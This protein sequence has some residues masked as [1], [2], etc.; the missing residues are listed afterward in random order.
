[1]KYLSDGDAS[2]W[3]VETDGRYAS[4]IKEYLSKD[5]IPEEGV[6]NIIFNAARALGYCPNPRDD[7]ENRETGLIIGKVQSG[8]TS[9]FISLTAL[10]F[11]NNYDIVIV[12]GGTKNAL[13]SQN[14]ERIREYFQ[15]M[16]N[17]INVLDTNENIELLNEQRISQFIRM[18]RKIVIVSLKT[19]AKINLLINN[20]FDSTSLSEKPILIIDDEGDEASLNTLVKKGKKSA[21]Y[22]AIEKLKGSLRRHCFISVTA[23]PQANMLIE[24][25]DV[26][27]PDFGLLVDPGEGYCGLDVFHG[28]GSQNIIPI[29]DKETSLL[30]D[31]IPNSFFTALSIFFVGCG[32]MKY[33]G[34]RPNE[35]FSMLIHPSQLKA[36]HSKAFDKTETLLKKWEYFARN[37]KD[38][39]YKELRD[40]LFEAYNHYQKTIALPPFEILEPEILNAI[41]CCGRHVVNGNNVPKN[42]DKYYPYNIYVGGNLLGRGLTLKG[43]AITYIIRTAKGVSTVDTVQQRARWFGYKMKYIDLCRVFA[44]K[45]IIKEFSEIRDHEEDL[46]STVRNANLQ[47]ARFKEI[48]RIFVLSDSMRMTR[49]S[50]ANTRNY[51]FSFWNYQRIFQAVPEYR[52]NNARVIEAFR[53]KYSHSLQTLT[54]GAARPHKVLY[55]CKYDEVK[56]EIIDKFIFPEGSKLNKAMLDKLSILMKE[57]GI[58]PYIDVIWMRDGEPAKHPVIDGHISN[59]MVG[60]RP[61][62]TTKPVVY[63]GDNN[64][65]V[66]DDM[67]QLQ[68]HLIQKKDSDECSHTLALYIPKD[69]VAQITNLVIRD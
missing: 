19:S 3:T 30:D 49:A 55:N 16:D 13:V 29:P 66:K 26:L 17:E 33:R 45:K 44:S 50:V 56:Q 58:L 57:K 31:G 62:D 37:D 67:M 18:G 2:N 7:T 65:L 24:A 47:G 21:T 1:M 34:M 46:W 12:L 61:Q 11:D 51:S 42:A 59:Y 63:P 52:D 22:R 68:I 54:F 4:S 14:S 15:A 23:T 25:L 38:I 27:S 69:Y 6:S 5:G 40:K 28:A 35:K 9:N 32:I 10:A 20:L 8:K 36:D 64:M 60:R 39:S 43:L 48:A 53:N 41:Q